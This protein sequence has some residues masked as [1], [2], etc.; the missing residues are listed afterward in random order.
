MGMTVRHAL[1]TD[2]D[3]VRDTLVDGFREDPYFRW[4]YPDEAT[5]GELAG[6]WFALITERLMT[7]GHTYLVDEGAAVAIFIPPDVALAEDADL[8]R[9]AEV[10]NRQLG[11]ERAMEVLT[12]LGVMADHE[13]KDTL[14]H[15]QCVY[16]ACRSASRG[17]GYGAEVMRRVT[18]VCDA[19]ELGA[20]LVSSNP[21]NVSFYE[22][23]GYKV[24]TDVTPI[25]GGPLMRPMWRQPR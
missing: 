14:P 7:R 10:L 20:Y 13:P 11:D 12:T 16:I 19:E 5:Y 1:K 17:C 21:L 25:E 8:G 15:F 18:E 22:R 24:L 2:I 4:Q 23:E 9:V 3:T 6:E